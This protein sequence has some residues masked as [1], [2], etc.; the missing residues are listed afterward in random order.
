GVYRLIRAKDKPKSDGLLRLDEAVNAL[1][2]KSVESARF[3]LRLMERFEM[4]YPVEVDGN[5]TVEQ[6]TTW[7][8]PGSLDPYQPEGLGE[9]WKGPGAVRL[10]YDYRSP[11]AEGIIPR[12]IVLTHA[13]HVKGDALWR[14]GVVIRDGEAAALV[15]VRRGDA[16]NFVEVAALGPAAARLR[17]LEVVQGAMNRINA[18][19]PGKPPTIEKELDGLPEAAGSVFKPIADLRAAEQA[20]AP[21]IVGT[22]PP[23]M[24]VEPTQQLDVVSERSTREQRRK[25][26]RAFLSYSHQDRRAK[27]EFVVNMLAMQ[28]KELILS[29]HD[30]MIEPGTE[31]QKEIET[32]LESMDIFIGLLTNHFVT[33]SFIQRVELAAARKRLKD[34]GKREFVFVLVL[35]DDI[36]LEGLDL[37]QYQ[38]LKPAHRAVCKHKSK[39]DGFNEAQREIEKLI[40][41]HMKKDDDD[42]GKPVVGLSPDL[43]PGGTSGVT[44]IHVSGDFVHGGKHMRDDRRINI[45]GNVTNSQVGQTLTNCT[46]LVNQQAPGAKKDAMNTLRQDVEELIKALP[47][48]K[49]DDAPQIAENLEL[50]LKQ[51]AKDKPDRKW[52]SVSAEG[53]MEAAGW[54]EGFTGKIGGAIKNLGTSLFPDFQLPK[55]GE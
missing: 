19:L 32:Q 35:V 55:T 3:L 12:F 24:R 23:P 28:A 48:A 38:I 46:N 18:D 29:W 31:W 47:A 42:N 17:L 51:A 20:E 41:D 25:P 15:R 22:T 10:R 34:R 49:V 4:C 16:P 44:V 52:Y 2:D 40:R 36:P 13:L 50:A 27:N 9:Q 43:P 53:L 30:G 33:S 11:V 7:L 54:V 21:I 6:S 26:L 37:S 45:G 39:K 14:N 8:V 1:P 5:D